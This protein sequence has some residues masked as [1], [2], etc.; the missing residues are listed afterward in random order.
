MIYPYLLE[1]KPLYGP[2]TSYGEA[3]KAV[4][5][6]SREEAEAYVKSFWP[7]A[8]IYEHGPEWTVL[9]IDWRDRERL[10][11]ESPNIVIPTSLSMTI[12]C[13]VK[14][15]PATPEELLYFED[16]IWRLAAA[17]VVEQSRT[18]E[19]AAKI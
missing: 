10:K 7:H 1:N 11:T 17:T 15:I 8:F 16:Y 18:K 5:E 14:K 3:V 19:L 12:F 6:M 4:R 9:P 13:S 2:Y